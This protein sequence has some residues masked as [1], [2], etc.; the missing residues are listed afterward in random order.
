MPTGD[1]DIPHL[2][3][4][5]HRIGFHS[6]RKPVA[7]LPDVHEPDLLQP[8]HDLSRLSELDRKRSLGVAYL[9]LFSAQLDPMTRDLFHDRGARLLNEVSAEGLPD[10]ILDSALSR[11]SHG[12]Q[13]ALVVLAAQRALAHPDLPGPD[14]CDA[15]YFIAEA[16]YQQQ[17]YED[18]IAVLNELNRLRRHV[19][20]WVL[21]ANCYQS[22]GHRTEEVRALEHAATIHPTL[23]DVR[24]RLAEYYELK[25]NHERAAYHRR[26]MGDP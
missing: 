4:T 12:Q 13:P 18:A 3:F 8:V 19:A 22:L 23:K 17:K 16:Y 21:L 25:G 20:Y 7:P 24:Q 5:H 15:L 2:A 6:D 26:R 1:T 11:L 14:R 9:Q 10:A